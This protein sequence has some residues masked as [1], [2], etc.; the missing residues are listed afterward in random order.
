ME[1]FVFILQYSFY[2]KSAIISAEDYTGIK[3]F[4]TFGNE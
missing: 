3:G 4:T 2:P 1:A